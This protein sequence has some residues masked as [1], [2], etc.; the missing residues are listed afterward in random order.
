MIQTFRQRLA[1]LSL[2]WRY[3]F[4]LAALLLLFLLGLIV[5]T[6]RFSSVLRTSRLEQ[7]QTSFEKNCQ[8][9][10]RDIFKTYA[11]PTVIE[12]TDDFATAGGAGVP[13]DLQ[14]M[15]RFSHVRDAFSNLCAVQDLPTES[16]LYFRRNGI[17]VTRSRLFPDADSFF[18]SYLSYEN[19]AQMPDLTPTR[20]L[21]R[22]QLLPLRTISVNGKAPQPYLTLLVCSTTYDTVYGFLYPQADVLDAFQLDTLPEGTALT[23]T[24]SDG[25]PILSYQTPEDPDDYVWLTDR[26]SAVSCDVSLGVPL[27]YFDGVVRGTQTTAAVSFLL[28]ALIGLAACLLFAHLSVRPYRRLIRAHAAEHPG[29]E[30]ADRGEH[31][32]MLQADGPGLPAAE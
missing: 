13:Y 18:G 23:F 15:Y 27:S 1:R 22:L 26:V 3:F 17:C 7:V 4:L 12:G 2:F 8:L 24:Q 28:F 5:A 30:N 20:I 14:Y 19:P 11:L 32:R 31:L 29:G 21:P 10:S 16:F 25:V 9:F 6:A